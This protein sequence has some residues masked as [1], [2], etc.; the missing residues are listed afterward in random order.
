M[1][2]IICNTFVYILPQLT[3][4]GRGQA[5]SI[6]LQ[7]VNQGQTEHCKWMVTSECPQL[8]HLEVLE[9]TLDIFFGKDGAPLI[10]RR[11]LCTQPLMP[12][13]LLYSVEANLDQGLESV[14]S[15][16][17]TARALP[18]CVSV[19]KRSHNKLIKN[20]IKYN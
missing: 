11:Y 1:R 7:Q 6:N 3:R 19:M 14:K 16:A 5:L 20:K 12:W 13:T 4:R 15:N 10:L 9:A 2:E 18:T 17:A 8:P